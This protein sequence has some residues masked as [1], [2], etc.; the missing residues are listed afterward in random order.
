MHSINRL[1]ILVTENHSL[2]SFSVGARNRHSTNVWR[3]DGSVKQEQWHFRSLLPSVKI[4]ML[5]YHPGS[6]SVAGESGE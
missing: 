3:V 2:L 1:I 5:G 6:S 4:S